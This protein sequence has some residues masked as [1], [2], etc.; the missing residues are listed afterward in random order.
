MESEILEDVARMENAEDVELLVEKIRT[1]GLENLKMEELNA[2]FMDRDL[3]DRIREIAETEKEEKDMAEVYQ[4]RTGDTREV[5]EKKLEE[6]RF[7]LAV[8]DTIQSELKKKGVI[9][10]ESETT[11][12][13]ERGRK[14]PKKLARYLLTIFENVDNM[15]KNNIVYRLHDQ[16][17]PAE[18]ITITLY[19]GWAVSWG[20]LNIKNG[21]YK[22]N[23]AVIKELYHL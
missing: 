1:I 11:A 15:E 4:R 21:S 19:I 13:D 12:T 9:R 23:K 22:I 2:V 7:F 8:N 14:P 20:L 10:I 16:G 5:F 17:Y 3:S 18:D 6:A